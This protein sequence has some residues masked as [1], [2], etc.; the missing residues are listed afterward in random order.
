M[1]LLLNQDEA[2][3]SVR[4]ESFRSDFAVTLI[5]HRV[6]YRTESAALPHLRILMV[7]QTAIPA[8]TTQLIS[9]TMTAMPR[10]S[11]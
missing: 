6:G 2:A 11:R 5:P 4:S 1:A 8:I 3:K 7:S 10:M 9:D